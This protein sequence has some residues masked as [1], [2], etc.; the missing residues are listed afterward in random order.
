MVLETSLLSPFAAAP[1]SP[2]PKVLLPQIALIGAH[3]AP[4]HIR[5]SERYM[6]PA[7]HSS[8]ALDKMPSR[9]YLQKRA[10]SDD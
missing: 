6:V 8:A 1:P 2:T 9:F 5:Y 4:K 7:T 10:V 3:S